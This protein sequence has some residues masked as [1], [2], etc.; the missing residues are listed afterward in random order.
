MK[1]NHSKVALEWLHWQEYCLLESPDEV[2]MTRI[3]HAANADEYRIP[4]SRYTVDGD[5]AQTSTVH[6]F[7]GCFWHGCTKCYPNRSEKHLRLEDR[8]M[9]EVYR[10]TL[11]KL[12]FLRDKGYNV[13][14]VWECEWERMKKER[15]EIK[16][17][18]DSLD[19]VEPLNSRDAF[20]GGHTNAIKLYHRS[21][22]ENGEE[23]KYY[24]YTSLYPYVNKNAMY[25]LGHPEIV[26]QPGHT[27]IPRF[28]GIAKCTV[29]TPK[30]LYHPVLPLL[31]NDK[32]TFPL[33]RT[34]V[35]EEMTK[36]MLERS[37]IC[38]HTDEQRQIIGTWCTPELEVAVE[39]G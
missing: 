38:N 30:E 21:D 6:E 28:I 15:E 17:F 11:N 33:C 3:Q 24:D 35:K 22:E 25:P 2:V 20:C 8:S 14:T 19:I 16:A 39:K 31:Q 34:C 23:I 29:Q 37:C 7:Q 27:N 32:L 12:Q 9:E 13:V 18:V 36:P 26:F 1:T 4:N 10:C 5:D